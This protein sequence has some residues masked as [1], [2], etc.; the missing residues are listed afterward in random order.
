MK[1][2]LRC[3]KLHKFSVSNG[4]GRA[5]AQREFM[6]QHVALPNNLSM[7]VRAVANLFESIS[8]YMEDLPFLKDNPK[9]KDNDKVLRTNVPFF[10]QMELCDMLKTQEVFALSGAETTCKPQR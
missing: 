10:T 5:E 1:G 7:D 9:Y 6:S 3:I 2:V 8:G 4:Y